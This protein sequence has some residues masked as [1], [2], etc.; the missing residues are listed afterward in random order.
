VGRGDAYVQAGR[1][2]DNIETALRALGSRRE[3]VVRLRVFVTDIA[4][5]DP[6]SRAVSERFLAIRPACTLVEVSRLVDPALRVEI[7]ADADDSLEPPEQRRP[8]T[9]LPRRGSRR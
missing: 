5:F 2:L 7:E 1:A 8:S 9:V 6:V 3:S 4:D